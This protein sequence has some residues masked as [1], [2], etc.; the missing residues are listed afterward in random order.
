MSAYTNLM[1]RNT[2]TRSAAR[3]IRVA[4]PHIFTEEPQLTIAK[5]FRRL[6]TLVEGG[7]RRLFEGTKLLENSVLEIDYSGLTVKYQSQPQ[8]L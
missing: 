5:Y 7:N 1:S 8:S 3:E 2:S 6:E 4:L